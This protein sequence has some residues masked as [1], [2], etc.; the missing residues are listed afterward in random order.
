[1]AQAEYMRRTARSSCRG[2]DLALI[3]HHDLYPGRR[4]ESV[5]IVRDK[6]RRLLEAI[7]R[8]IA[9]TRFPL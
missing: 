1:V 5:F 7:N 2:P 3:D 8:H 9:K 6:S 4:E